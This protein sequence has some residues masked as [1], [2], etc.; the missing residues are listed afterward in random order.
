MTLFWYSSDMVKKSVTVGNRNG[1]HVRPSRFI[2]QTMDGTRDAVSL[3]A[4]GISITSLS[5]IN[6][7]TLGLKHG[8]TCI[9]TVEGDDALH[10]MEKIE[11]LM[12]REYDFSSSI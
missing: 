4:N 3:E 9:I 7:L 2:A 10:T 11:S 6:I 12:T 5:M 8:D 1:I